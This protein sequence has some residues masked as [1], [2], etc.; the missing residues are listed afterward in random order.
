MIRFGS[1]LFS[2]PTAAMVDCSPSLFFKTIR[3][4]GRKEIEAYTEAT[5]NQPWCRNLSILCLLQLMLSDEN[6]GL[7]VN[8]RNPT[9]K[10][11]GSLDLIGAS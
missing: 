2:E 9:L 1:T 11:K 6:N 4:S 8:C 7:T 10:I 5:E 3:G